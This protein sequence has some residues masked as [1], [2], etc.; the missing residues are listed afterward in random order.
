MGKSQDNWL[1]PQMRIYVLFCISRTREIRC[2]KCGVWT[3]L[4]MHHTKYA[5]EEVVTINDIMILCQKCH[6]N[7]GTSI[8]SVRTV[9]KGKKRFCEISG[10]KF[11]Y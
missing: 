11:E 2:E 5:P 4:E 9:F 3:G 6:R 1:S 7:C 8:S 10:H